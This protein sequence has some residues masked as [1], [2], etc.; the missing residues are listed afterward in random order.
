MKLNLWVKVIYILSKL[1]EILK[2]GLK[3]T[4]HM[5]IGRKFGKFFENRKGVMEV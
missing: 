2:R 1:I 4:E 3:K 5:K